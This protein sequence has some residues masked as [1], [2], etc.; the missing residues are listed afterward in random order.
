MQQ[1]QFFVLQ[2]PNGMI[3]VRKPNSAVRGRR[4]TALG[5]AGQLF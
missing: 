3:C 2:M 1:C 5:I 4:L